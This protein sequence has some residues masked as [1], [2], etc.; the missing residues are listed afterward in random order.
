[1][2]EFD[3]LQAARDDT[4]VELPTEAEE[5]AVEEQQEQET[6]RLQE[7]DKQTEQPAETVEPEEEASEP[8][9]EHQ[10]PLHHLL[11]ERQSRQ[12]LQ[13][14]LER[15]KEEFAELKGKLPQAP[16]PEFDEDPKSYIDASVEEVSKKGYVTKDDL[17]KEREAIEADAQN[18]QLMAALNEDT[19]VIGEKHRDFPKALQHT[20]EYF[21]N[22]HLLSGVPPKDI[23]NLIAQTE[24]NIARDML[25]KGKSPSEFVYE[26]AV[27]NLGYKPPEKQDTTKIDNI[28]RGQK[29]ST[30]LPS[31]DGGK[32]DSGKS[33]ADVFDEAFAESFSFM[34][35]K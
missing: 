3:A 10:V 5:Q 4:P 9:K 12:E 13:K 18:K 32:P 23:P 30:P 17:R 8:A 1:M 11:E 31:G 35:R 22:Q 20:R 26:Y 33:A 28:R 34:K 29:A 21:Y 19:R 16:K 15:I 2:A 27:K 14:E 6:Q 24:L 7:F 25:P